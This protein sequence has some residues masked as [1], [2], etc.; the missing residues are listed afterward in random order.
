MMSLVW[1]LRAFCRYVCPVASFISL[2][3]MAGRLMVRKRN[4]KVCQNCKQ[5]PCLRGNADG[6]ACPYGLSVAAIERN[7]DCGICTEC[8]KSCPHDNVSLA[9]RHGAW[10]ER[11]S[12]YGEAW[13]AIVLLVLAM[14]YSLS[15]HSPWPIMRDM[16][17]VIDKATWPEFG[18]YA[19]VLWGVALGVV[20]LIFWLATGWGMGLSETGTM[21]HGKSPVRRA[22]SRAGIFS[23]SVSLSRPRV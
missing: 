12:S 4:A 19:A 17:N 22:N 21:H 10:T 1:E 18:L 9:W 23:A 2:Y 3:S 7:V 13:Q 6:W 11:F 8:F 16:V 20:P 14:A 5:K 15:V